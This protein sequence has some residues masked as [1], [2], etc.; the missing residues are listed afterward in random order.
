MSQDGIE[1]SSKTRETLEQHNLRPLWEI[2]ENE[3]G[4][5]RDNLEAD[6]WKWKDIR[7]AVDRISDDIPSDLSPR[8]TV[9]VNVS[10]NVAISHTFSVGVETA[11]PGDTTPAHRHSG[12]F[13]RFAIDGHPEM[14]TAVGG[15]EFPM[16]DNDLVTI[17]Q[18]EWHGHANE[19]DEKTAWLVIDDSPLR[20]DTLKAG[21][22]FE[23][24]DNDRQAITRPRGYHKSRYGN[25][26]PRTLSNGIPGPLEGTCDPTPPYRFPWDVMSDSL[27]YAKDNEDAHSPNDGVVVTYTNPRCGTGPL[28]PTFGVRAHRL[29]E[30]EETVAHSHNATEVFYVIEGSGQT[31]VEGEPF[32]WSGQDIFVIPSYKAHSHNPDSE[33]TLLTI[34][35]R[36]LLEAINLYHEFE[37]D[38]HLNC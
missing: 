23:W 19:S 25:C 18:W 5:T 38:P 28:F 27:D 34:T 24:H 12:H 1:L 16:V 3:L 15:E 7:A 4:Q 14:K 29:L 10:Y 31:F 8:V 32:D 11:P 35:N 37:K 22:L 17:P 20:I 2:A 6:I 21:N 26:C 36:P 33:A 13:L 9:P 30:G